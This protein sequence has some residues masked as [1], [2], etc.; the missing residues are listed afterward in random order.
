MISIPLFSSINYNRETSFDEKIISALSDYFYLG[1][2]QVEVVKGNEVR[3]EED[4]GKVSWLT[5]ALKVASYVLLFP[6]TCILF[7]I[8]QGLRSQYSFT[9]IVLSKPDVASQLV[10]EG[11]PGKPIERTI[12]DTKERTI[13]DTSED[14]KAGSLLEN[15]DNLTLEEPPRS[16]NPD[17]T[18]SKIP[19]PIKEVVEKSQDLPSPI[20]I[21]QA[22]KVEGIAR[23]VIIEEKYE[24]YSWADI[25][26]HRISCGS[27]HDQLTNLEKILP[28]MVPKFFG[29]SHKQIE[30]LLSDGT[31]G[32]WT[33]LQSIPNEISSFEKNHQTFKNLQKSIEYDIMKASLP[34]EE[35]QL[36]AFNDLKHTKSTLIVRSSSNEDGSVVNAGGNE[37]ISGVAP[38]EESLKAALAKVVSSY[39]SLKSFKNRAAFENPLSKL[40]LCSVLIMEQIIETPSV[41]IVSGVMMTNELAWTSPDEEGNI[42][43][44][45]AWGFANG[46]RGTV[47]CDEWAITD[48]FT[49]STI[50]RKFYRTVP[51]I[52]GKETKVKNTQDFRGKPSL[53]E[54]QLEQLQ[55]IAKKF[56]SSFGKSMNVEFVIKGENLYIVQAR[57]IQA[58]H[59]S[60]TTTKSQLRTQ[61]GSLVEEHESLSVKDGLFTHP[62]RFPISISAQG[63]SFQEKKQH[64]LILKLQDLLA[65]N[66]E[67]LKGRLSDIKETLDKT[68]P[69]LIE[70]KCGQ[71]WQIDLKNIRNYS[72]LIME[73]MQKAADKNQMTQL[74]FHAR[75]LRKFVQ[76]E[77]LVIGA[78]SLSG[79]EVATNLP[80]HFHD[81]IKS[82]E[83]CSIN[84]LALLGLNGFDKQ[85][86]SK[87]LEF[88]K[89]NNQ[90]NSVLMPKLLGE[91]EMLNSLNPATNWLS[92]NFSG[93]NLPKIEEL[94]S[95][96][97][98]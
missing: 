72:N 60:E 26:K 35:W 44:T 74:A 90:S 88:L 78:D 38:T 73:N 23:T 84:E 7:A 21:N 31:K 76:L 70:R 42:H 2:A 94:I 98:S 49:Y 75:M 85:I 34:I 9:P 10:K 33:R 40:P 25:V 47:A 22:S 15:Q 80:D 79:L 59:L 36:Q 48:D 61:S 28:G 41:P 52:L 39:F 20:I 50:R 96:I 55:D 8:N 71:T 82:E 62:A 83:N 19:E 17:Q 65:T 51:T 91:L 45:A 37:T 24:P 92:E 57:P 69:L 67:L 97:E 18:I 63:N 53:H 64:P 16:G 32:L 93:S 81:F 5:L 89:I 54:T 6:L 11:E 30:S 1:G 95:K 13:E 27:K 46:T 77:K 56:E 12:E 43:I 14:V 58:L 86:Q 29:F 4:N 3:L 66:P 68:I 87:W